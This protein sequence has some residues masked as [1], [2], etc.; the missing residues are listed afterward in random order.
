M[1]KKKP[2]LDSELTGRTLNRMIRTP[3][4]QSTLHNQ[5][6]GLL[7]NRTKPLEFLKLLYSL[8]LEDIDDYVRPFF[9]KTMTTCLQNLNEAAWQSLALNKF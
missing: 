8:E 7:G 6:A 1:K 5:I 4:R 9:S 3:Y 2:G